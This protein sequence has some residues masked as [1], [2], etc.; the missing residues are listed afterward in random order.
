MATGLGED[1]ALAFITHAISETGQL[2]SVSEICALA[3]SLGVMTVVD[4]A[5]SLGV[6]PIDLGQWQADAVLGSCVKWCCAG[7]G[8]AFLWLSDR[9]AQTLEPV[10]LGWFSHEAPFE[11][12]IH[13][14]RYAKGAK[15]FWGA[16]LPYCLTCWQRRHCSSCAL[17][18]I[19]K[20]INT[21]S[22]WGRGSWIV[23]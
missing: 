22:A 9:L 18:A 21:I 6:I 8:A 3:R 5:Q 14:F 4:I 10:D 7:P 2:Q 12:D 19:V 13:D 16:R 20:F 23:P 11:F 17:S 1:V 15:R